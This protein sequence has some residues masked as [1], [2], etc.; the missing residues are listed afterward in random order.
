MKTIL[1]DM[2]DTI[3]N[4]TEAWVTLVNKRFGTDVDPLSLRD[5]DVSKAFPELT[6]E[7]VYGVT[8][9]DEFWYSVRPIKG[10][11]EYLK[12]LIDDGNKVFIVTCAAYETLKIKMEEVLFR[13]FPYITWS[14]VIIASKKQLIKADYLVDDGIHNHIGGEY[15]SL[16]FT[17]PHNCEYNAEANGM[18]RVNNW[19][20]VYKYISE[21]K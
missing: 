14:D 17:A 5:W 3:E 12:K 16:L 10:A 7:Q 15:K 9:E 1:V 6:R 4:C 2:D 8:F 20:E 21:N 19:E 11:V 13:Y 18:V